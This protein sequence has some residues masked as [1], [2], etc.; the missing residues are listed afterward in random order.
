M[1]SCNAGVMLWLVHKEMSHIYAHTKTADLK[2]ASAGY[3]IQREK[4]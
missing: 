4:F 1:S 3:P 2:L